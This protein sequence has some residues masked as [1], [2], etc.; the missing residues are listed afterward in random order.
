[1]VVV[2]AVPEAASLPS[3]PPRARF[4]LTVAEA[5][6]NRVSLQ[7]A[8]GLRGALHDFLCVAFVSCSRRLLVRPGHVQPRQVSLAWPPATP[9]LLIT[10]SD[11]AVAHDVLVFTSTRRSYCL[12]RASAGV[13]RALPPH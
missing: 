7:A 9:S 4:L 13:H 8:L 2:P 12:L 1:M 3:S 5:A 10:A 11:L 6:G